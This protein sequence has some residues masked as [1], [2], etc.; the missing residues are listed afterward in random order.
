M[1]A[2]PVLIAIFALVIGFMVVVRIVTKEKSSIEEYWT[3]FIGLMACSTPILVGLFFFGYLGAF[4]GLVVTLFI[5]RKIA[6]FK[7]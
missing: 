4:L 2:L 5:L 7:N 3:M 6:L 1:N